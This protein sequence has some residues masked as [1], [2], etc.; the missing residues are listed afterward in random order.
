VKINI[1]LDDIWRGR[2]YSMSECPIALA[3]ARAVGGNVKVFVHVR[4]GT[5]VGEKVFYLHEIASAFIDRFD[6][7]KKVEPFSFD[8]E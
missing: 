6:K 2:P 3:I 7:G 1:T 5:V 8:L 4:D